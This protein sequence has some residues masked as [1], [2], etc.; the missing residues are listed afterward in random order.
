MGV[1]YLSLGGWAQGCG[2]WITILCLAL[3]LIFT[4]RAQGVL[5]ILSRS[6]VVINY[7]VWGTPAVLTGDGGPP[8]Y[9]DPSLALAFEM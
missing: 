2:V 9:Q 6:P 1:I 8:Q 3:F 7:S 4:L 5:A